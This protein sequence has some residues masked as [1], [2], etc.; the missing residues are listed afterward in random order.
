MSGYLIKNKGVS[1]QV[2]R[3]GEPDACFESATVPEAFDWVDADKASAI[4]GPLIKCVNCR[5]EDCP[6][7]AQ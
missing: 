5:P 3:P 6:C 2:M 7:L 4:G 1:V